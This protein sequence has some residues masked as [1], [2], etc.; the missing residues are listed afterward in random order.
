MEKNPELAAFGERVRKRR[1][2]LGMS[3]QD[4]ALRCDYT[5][6]T[7]I[8]KIESGSID[9]PQSKIMQLARALKTSNS[10]LMG[11][12]VEEP[13]NIVVDVDK[14]QSDTILKIYKKL[15]SKYR[16]K[17]AEFAEMLMLMQDTN[18]GG[19]EP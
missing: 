2:Y 17:L 19:N 7:S 6:R 10:Y 14:A 5:S 9:I 16:D 18:N 15:N 13:T 8:A 1:I 12:E 3:Q 11:W 4:L